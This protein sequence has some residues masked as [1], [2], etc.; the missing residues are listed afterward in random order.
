MGKEKNGFVYMWKNLDNQ[1]KYIGYHVGN[2][3]DGYVCS[4]HNKSFWED[5][6]NDKMSWN[7]IILFIGNS[8]SCL[9]EEQRLLKNVNLRSDEY[10]NNA[11]GSEIIFTDEVKKKM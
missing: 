9:I 10:Y 6:N 5:F 3:D 7:R 1:K 8:T 11:R 2:L 4:S